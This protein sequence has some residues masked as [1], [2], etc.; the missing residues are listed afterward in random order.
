MSANERQT[1]PFLWIQ[2]WETTMQGVGFPRARLSVN[3]DA[4]PIELDPADWP[5]TYSWVSDVDEHLLGGIQTPEAWNMAHWAF[6]FVDPLRPERIA[7]SPMLAE[8]LE[9]LTSVEF[10]IEV[11][12]IEIPEAESDG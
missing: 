12:Q 11:F 3:V 9:E 4:A 1:S 2:A 7:P 10:A 8:I 6:T 5:L